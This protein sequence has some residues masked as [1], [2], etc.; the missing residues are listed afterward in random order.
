MKTLLTSAL[1]SIAAP[2]MAQTP[3]APAPAQAAA[4]LSSATTTIGDLLANPAARAIVDKHLPGFSAN[5]QVQM[6]LG[7]TLAGAQPFSNGGITDEA[8][9][10][11]DKD[12]ATLPSAR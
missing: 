10:A 6:G 5:P 7:L 3:P 11:I 8:R 9:V 12:L 1:L 2:A 4:A